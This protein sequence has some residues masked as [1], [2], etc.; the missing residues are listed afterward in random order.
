[1]ISR[2]MAEMRRFF[3]LILLAFLMPIAVFA[4]SAEPVPPGSRA[5]IETIRLD[6]Q[7]IEAA[8]SRDSLTDSRLNEL[9][10]RLTP[11]IVTIDEII[12]R[13]QPRVDEIKARIDQLGP[14]PD[15]SKGQ[16]ESAEVA[17]DRA[18][19][20][21][22]WKEA[23]ETLRLARGL[24]LRA[25]QTSQALS[26]RR[27]QNFTREIL[28]QHPAVISP[29]LWVEVT[30]SLPADLRAFNFLMQQWAETI[31]D[32]LS[33]YEA[34]VLLL[35]VAAFSL[36]QPR[37]RRWVETGSFLRAEELVGFNERTRLQKLMR[38]LR[39]LALA[40]FVPGAALLLLDLLLDR[41]ELLPGRANSVMDSVLTGLI[42][43]AF[44]R[45]LSRAV[46]APG[47]SGW[48]IVELSDERATIFARTIFRFT[49]VVIVGRVV[50][51]WL[52]AIVA[53]FPLTL[54]A[55]GIFAILAVLVVARGLNLAFG[56]RETASVEDL[57]EAGRLWH[58]R[59]LG[60]I[61]VVAVIGAAVSG[62]VPFASFLVTQL[63]W[64]TA[65]ALAAIL[66]LA[67]V[68]ELVGTGLSSQ[69]FLGKRVRDATGMAA[70]ALD[71][72]SVL[73]SGFL[74]LV[75]LVALAMLVLAPWGVDSQSFLSN[76]RAAFFG[77]QVGGITISLS[78]IALA[79]GLFGV[80]Y[81]ITRA[82]QNWLDLN[83]LPRTTLD[84]G[85]Q[86]SIRTILGYI[87]IVIAAM[88]ALSQL[89]LSLDKLT[90][91]AGALS[92]GIGFG[93]KSIVE[94]FIS[95]LILLWE[96]PIRVGDWIV[97][98]DE[99]GTVKRINVRS[100]EILT[101]DRAS[102]IIPNSEFISGRVK[103]WVHADRTARIIVPVGVDY[104]ADP[105]VVQKILLDAALA[106]IEIMSEPK[107]MVIFK[108]LGENGLDFE[109]RCFTDVDSMSTT[110]SDLL[111]DIYRRLQEAGVTVSSPTRRLEITNLPPMVDP[112]G[113]PR[114]ED[115]RDG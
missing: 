102:L 73:G 48:R 33:W 28:A 110:R 5:Q 95:G 72:A 22:L 59:L 7:Q 96:R 77:F 41:F 114:A 112:R 111:F 93:L 65:L 108:N 30:K 92:V 27:R 68:E 78:T 61:A 90:I 103:N 26:D 20:N 58:V 66:L 89:G 69:G 79:I 56:Q 52:A 60:W 71:Q 25:E 13:E 45:G 29:W 62:Y 9:R 87:G 98:G 17:R 11:L 32:N 67:F 21:R 2:T 4:Q 10:Q 54:A 80:G 106:H 47:R 23:D 15:L 94:N 53:S 74:R 1:M 63:T 35:L 38:A 107:P 34:A 113:L 39:R 88:F 3:T 16:N 36:I 104:S 51:A 85:L 40:I 100:T 31:V 14:A 84:P 55:R 83:Y 76:I 109:L 101:F 6:L 18:E 99:Q 57:A 37:A 44:M 75:L 64:V 105:Q 12:Q 46:L 97:V 82:I 91:V 86:N 49:L 81:F 19:Q 50:D 43:L 70:S 24:G 8:L 115:E 42:F